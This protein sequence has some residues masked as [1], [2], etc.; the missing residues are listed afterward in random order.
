V[1]FDS[2]LDESGVLELTLVLDLFVDL[3]QS[4]RLVSLNSHLNGSAGP[5]RRT[6]TLGSLRSIHRHHRRLCE[7]CTTAQQA[8]EPHAS[9]E[10]IQQFQFRDLR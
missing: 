5:T 10:F 7:P 4:S 3:S 9:F 1:A 6:A 8:V 2:R